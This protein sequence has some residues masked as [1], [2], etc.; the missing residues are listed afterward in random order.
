MQV[1][2]WIQTQMQ[3]QMLKYNEIQIHMKKYKYKWRNTAANNGRDQ[4][5][6]EK[7]QWCC[8]SL[9]NA[10]GKVNTNTNAN[11]NVEIQWNTNTHE[12]IQI[13]MKKYSSK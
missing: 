12:E 8:C 1:E 7:G 9:R 4:I 11:T 2:K 5:G 13:Q 10:S 6:W 3:I